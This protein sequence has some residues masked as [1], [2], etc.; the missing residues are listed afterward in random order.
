MSAK[1]ELLGCHR[2]SGNAARGENGGILEETLFPRAEFPNS[3]DEGVQ[4]CNYDKERFQILQSD[5]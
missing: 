5:T 1:P 4:V 2:G 3:D